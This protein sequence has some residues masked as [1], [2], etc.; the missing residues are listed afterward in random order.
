MKL[1]SFLTDNGISLADFSNSVKCSISMI[2][3][4]KSGQR[5]PSP[6]LAF[7]IEQITGGLVT[8]DELL[9]PELYEHLKEPIEK[10]V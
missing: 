2:S 1:S 9:F 6:E 5:R 3:R 10:A 4:I 7:R 8:R